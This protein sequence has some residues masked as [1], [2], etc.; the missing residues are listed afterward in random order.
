[1]AF[2]STFLDLQNTV[3]GKLRLDPN[4]DSQ[5]VKDWINQAYARVAVET[6]AFQRTDYDFF[7]AGA[8][9]YT[10]PTAILRIKEMVVAQNGSGQ[11]GAP[12]E[13]STVDTIM[14]MRQGSGGTDSG[15]PSYY[16]LSGI[17]RYEVFPTPQSSNDKV[18]FYYVYLP[19]ALAGD[20]D[21]PLLQEPFSSYLLEY[22][23]L[24]EAADFLTDPKVA[25]YRQ[26][27]EVWMRQ[28]RQHM[29]RKQGG[30]V[31]QL[32]VAGG[33]SWVPRDPSTDLGG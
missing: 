22:G 29:S 12:L 25:D 11:W 28:F 23:A 7:T 31:R 2:P 32:R 30:H 5:R 19:T 21:V 14:S 9:S 15:V 27:Y 3:I 24:A 18:R 1:M 26:L 20:T 33:S 10:L 17:D 8:G 4:Q 6:E 13:Q 16:A